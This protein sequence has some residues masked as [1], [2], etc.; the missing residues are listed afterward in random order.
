M[1]GKAL[2]IENTCFSL[3]NWETR[4]AIS[5]SGSLYYNTS[6]DLYLF[7]Y[8]HTVKFTLKKGSNVCINFIVKNMVTTTLMVFT[9]KKTIVNK[10]FWHNIKP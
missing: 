4:T 8:Y 6:T 9:G 7:V 2:F 5:S 3:Q 10:H 1:C